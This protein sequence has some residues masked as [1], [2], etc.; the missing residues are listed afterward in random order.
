M[1]INVE[2]LL[3]RGYIIIA[4]ISVINQSINHEGPRS[5]ISD[6]GSMNVVWHFEVNKKQHPLLDYPKLKKKKIIKTVQK[7]AYASDVI[8]FLV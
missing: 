3:G 1:L 4:V 2:W 8:R 7:I 6:F 5:L